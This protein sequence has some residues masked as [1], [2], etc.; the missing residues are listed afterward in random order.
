MDDIVAPRPAHLLLR[1]ETR[2]AHEDTEASGG[3]RRLM[4][5]ELDVAGY[6]ALLRAQLGLFDEW[7]A[8]RAGW[9][10]DVVPQAGW[11]YVSRASLLRGD[12]AVANRARSYTSRPVEG[13]AP[14]VGASPARDAPAPAPAPAP[15]GASPARDAPVPAGASPAGDSIHDS[16]TCWGELYVIEGSAL[17]G[18]L[19]VRRLREL[20]P[21][22][23]HRFYAI[24]EEAPSAWRRFQHILDTQ[25]H[26]D[27]S[28]RAAVDGARRMFARFRQTLMEPA[29]HV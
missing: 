14:P 9:L 2:E 16:A 10:A 12:L 18:R 22:R 5:G 6:E 24:G 8:E 4:D 26:D 7:E 21:D 17:G 25:L 1:E 11:S 13:H 19:I 15:V 29:A 23:D 20:Y 28:H 27:A 3:M